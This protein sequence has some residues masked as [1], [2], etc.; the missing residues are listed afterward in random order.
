MSFEQRL[1]G[2]VDMAMTLTE[3]TA[4]KAARAKRPSRSKA[5]RE[6][7]DMIDRALA[8]AEAQRAAGQQQLDY[9]AARIT[10][11]TRLR[12]QLERV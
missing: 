10:V 1:Y 9:A 7:L 6:M 2:E 12:D 3:H 4:V 11:L 5:K 8:E